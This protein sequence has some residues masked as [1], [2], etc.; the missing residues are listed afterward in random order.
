MSKLTSEELIT[1]R[2]RQTNTLIE[3]YMWYV[4]QAEFA[5]A[6][7]ILAALKLLLEKKEIK[8]VIQKT[9]QRGR[10]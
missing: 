9:K 10:G 7:S 5:R 4:E 2:Y 3:D 6:D 1:Q 8:K